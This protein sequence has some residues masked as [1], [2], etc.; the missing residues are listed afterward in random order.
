MSPTADVDCHSG[1]HAFRNPRDG[2]LLVFDELHPGDGYVQFFSP[3]RGELRKFLREAART[4][5]ERIS[6]EAL[7]APAFAAYVRYRASMPVESA[8]RPAKSGGVTTHVL[9]RVSGQS[10]ELRAVL[11]R[12]DVRDPKPLFV[13]GRAGTGKSA[14]LRQLAAEKEGQCV[15]LAPTGLAALNAGGQTIHSFFK[16][17]LKPLTPAD[18]QYG[19][20]VNVVQK[21]DTLII[22]EVSMVRADLLDGI[23]RALRVKAGGR[24]RP[25]GGVRVVMFGDPYQLPPVVSREDYP[26]FEELGYAGAHFFDAQVLGESPLAAIEFRTVYRQRDPAWVAVLDRLRMAT[27]Q[28]DDWSL[29]QS[30][31]RPARYDELDDTIILTAYR[32]DAEDINER[33]LALLEDAPATFTAERDGSFAGADWRRQDPAPDPLVLKRGARVMFVK[34]DAG[35]RWVNGSLGEVEGIRRREVRV[36]MDDGTVVVVEP[37]EWQQLVYE[38]DEESAEIRTR[39]VG[40]YRQLPLQLAWAVTIHKSQG[41]TFDRV[42]VHLGSGAFA[43]GQAYVALSRCR[44][45]E[46]LTLER[47]FGRRDMRCDPRVVEFMERAVPIGG[48]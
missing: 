36:R 46:G 43:A 41:L 13:T 7:C 2:D 14:V 24:G 1:L 40:R 33:R 23:D 21:L 17:P 27:L 19:Q 22:D 38:V 34:N 26:A 45:L 3:G 28:G 18:I 30:R 5:F 20:W 11:R 10:E 6:D 35:E 16:F 15:V 37:Q 31:V 8:R 9:R 12:L 32:K 48:G 25:F 42:H 39:V 29:L 4:N 47:P 44:T